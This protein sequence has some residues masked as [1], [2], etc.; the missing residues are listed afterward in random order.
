MPHSCCDVLPRRKSTYC[1][2]N[3][4]DITYSQSLYRIHIHPFLPVCSAELSTERI[5]NSLYQVHAI[6]IDFFLIPRV[7]SQM[8]GGS[9]ATRYPVVQ[10]YIHLAVPS[11]HQS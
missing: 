3:W 10:P 4:C 9:K 5:V 1:L 6:V 11:S 7:P 2:K 8:E